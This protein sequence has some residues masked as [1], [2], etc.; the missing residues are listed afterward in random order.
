[1]AEP[2]G[3]VVVLGGTGFLGR[4]VVGA[5]L[6]RGRPVAVGTRDPAGAAAQ[7][8]PNPVRVDLR[9]PASLGR[10]FAGAAAV[11]NCVGLYVERGAETFRAV[12]V[13]GAGAAAGAAAAAGV[14][15]FVHV[16]GIGADRASGSAYIRARAEGE[17][18]VRAAFPAATILR[19]GALFAED[20][21]L[22]AALAPIVARLPVLPLFG[23]GSTRLQPVHAGD[24]AEA[25]ARALEADA[26]PGTTYELGGPED[27]SYRE[28]LVRLAA[29]AGRR[30]LYLPVPFALWHGLAAAACVLPSP[31]ITPAQVA[32]MR[33]DNVAGADMPGLA[34]LGIA[35]RAASALGLV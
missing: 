5:L 8:L 35:P 33:R 24:V 25:A 11:V 26:A 31:P 23:D 15:R 34:E 3:S 22:F 10:A 12:H 14:R 9:D 18:A 2:G 6:A 21:G 20:G 19:P 1:M 27:F 29:R 13:E 4:R 30:R 7:G 32:L 28:I 17:A 16:S